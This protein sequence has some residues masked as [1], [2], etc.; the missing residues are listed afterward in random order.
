MTVRFYCTPCFAAEGSKCKTG[1]RL[2]QD[3]PLRRHTRW[4]LRGICLRQQSQQNVHIG[5]GFHLCTGIN[6]TSISA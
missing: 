5:S 4:K 6:N 3:V 1:T 2:V